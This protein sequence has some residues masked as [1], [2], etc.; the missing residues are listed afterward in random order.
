MHKFSVNSSQPSVTYMCHEKELSLNYDVY[1]HANPYISHLAP[2]DDW[3]N[4]D[5]LR[6][7]KEVVHLQMSADVDHFVQASMFQ[8][9]VAQWFHMTSKVLVNIDSYN[10]LL[11]SDTQSLPKPTCHLWG[12]LTFTK[13]SSAVNHLNE[14]EH[15]IFIIWFIS[16]R[17]K[18]FIGYYMSSCWYHLDNFLVR[19]LP[20]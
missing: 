16:H 14:V 7:V 13:D 12:P 18:Y 20:I 1:K 11:H 15:Y 6:W 3:W 17:A 8:L 19:V 2:E 4:T 10:G 5:R 9:I